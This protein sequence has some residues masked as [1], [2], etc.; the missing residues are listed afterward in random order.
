MFLFNSTECARLFH[1][2]HQCSPC[3]HTTLRMC[4]SRYRMMCGDVADIIYSFS[5]VERYSRLRVICGIYELRV[6]V[7]VSCLHRDNSKMC[8]IM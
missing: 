4:P 8:K 3:M 2:K 6:M 1:V 5:D 7:F